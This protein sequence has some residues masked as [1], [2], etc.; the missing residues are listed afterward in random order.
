MVEVLTTR[1]TDRAVDHAKDISEM[2]IIPG[3]LIDHIRRTERAMTRIK[4]CD[5]RRTHIRRTRLSA[6]AS[7]DFR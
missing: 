6:Q 1:L 3:P 5:L 4:C 2:E 7:G